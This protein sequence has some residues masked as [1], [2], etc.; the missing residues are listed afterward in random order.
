MTDLLPHSDAR[1]YSLH[2]TTPLAY[3]SRLRDPLCGMLITARHAD[4]T[5]IRGA[6]VIFVRWY[7]E[8]RSNNG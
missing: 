5:R 4:S 6:E 3:F 8:E 7:I 2:D 1:C